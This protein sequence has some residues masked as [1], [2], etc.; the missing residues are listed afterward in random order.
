MP[1]LYCKGS[2][3]TPHLHVNYH[4]VTSPRRSMA[5]VSNAFAQT[6]LF[7]TQQAPKQPCNAGLR[8]RTVQIGPDAQELVTTK[9]AS[10]VSTAQRSAPGMSRVS[11]GARG[12]SA[13][14]EMCICT[15]V[16]CI[17][18]KLCDGC[19]KLY[20]TL[21]HGIMQHLAPCFSTMTKEWINLV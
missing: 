7:C 14:S 10:R 8:G 2:K 13:S 3:E 9:T 4:V 20:A 19:G 11:S 17:L 18:R 12:T 15:L 1:T 5:C 21:L 6:W 16:R